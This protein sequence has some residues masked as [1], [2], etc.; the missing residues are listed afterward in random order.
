MLVQNEQ[1]M[2]LDFQ[3]SIH[4]EKGGIAKFGLLIMQVGLSDILVMV[5]LD[6]ISEQRETY[7]CAGG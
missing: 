3:H 6:P 2:N 1:L 5:F 4:K 7:V